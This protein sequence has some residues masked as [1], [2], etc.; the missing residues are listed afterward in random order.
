MKKQ[1]FPCLPQDSVT[2]CSHF[3]AET[4]NY[5]FLLLAL[6]GLLGVSHVVAVWG[7]LGL[8]SLVASP[9]CWDSRTCVFSM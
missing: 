2:N 1:E 4:K 8:V 7:W 3:I 9:R 6:L 5:Y